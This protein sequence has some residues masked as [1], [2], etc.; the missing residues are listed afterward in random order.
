MLD[1]VVSINR[2][3]N[4]P[5]KLE[6]VLSK[7]GRG[8]S[9]TLINK[10]YKRYKEKSLY[11]SLEDSLQNVFRKFNAL[12]AMD[13]N[14]R[15]IPRKMKKAFKKQF[16]INFVFMHRGIVGIHSP[17]SVFSRQE[18]LEKI[19]ELIEFHNPDRIYLDSFNLYY[20]YSTEIIGEKNLFLFQRKRAALEE[21]LS[22]GVPVVTSMQANRSVMMG[23]NEPINVNDYLENIKG[24]IDRGEIVVTNSRIEGGE[25]I[26]KDLITHKE[27]VIVDMDVFSDKMRELYLQDFS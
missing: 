11:I 21:V 18:L 8:K 24:Q 16:G 4:G 7:V 2:T 26:E 23:S 1:Q 14:K 15:R 13:G 25:L 12:K 5:K 17:A 9:L 3:K 19:K 10:S 20:T 6:I 27:E 22:L